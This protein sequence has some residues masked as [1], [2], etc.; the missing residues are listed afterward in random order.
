MVAGSPR[1]WLRQSLQRHLIPA[2]EANGFRLRPLTGEEATSR[3]MKS[4]FSFGQLRRESSRGIDLVEIQLYKR[5]DAAFRL[6]IGT[7]PFDGVDHPFGHVTAEQ[8]NVHSL[9]KYFAAYSSPRFRRWFKVRRWFG[10]SGSKVDY[11]NL[12]ADN[13]GL[14]REAEDALRDGSRGPHIRI[15]QA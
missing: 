5:G 9:S 11:E 13:L 12:V 8:A 7:V 6:N 4:A 14:V 15:V 1:Q 10:P 3:E 2:F